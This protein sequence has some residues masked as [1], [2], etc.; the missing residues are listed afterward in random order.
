MNCP[1]GIQGRCLEG[2]E[3]CSPGQGGRGVAIVPVPSHAIATGV[4]F[5]GTNLLALSVWEYNTK[6]KEGA[7]MDLPRKM[8]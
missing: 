2:A 1:G 6:Y 4:M 8:L 7:N 3:F 5:L